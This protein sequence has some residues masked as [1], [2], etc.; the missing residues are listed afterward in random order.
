MG[1]AIA[2]Q[3][4]DGMPSHLEATTKGVLC[5]T[6]TSDT[7]SVT[8]SKCL[9]PGLDTNA[10]DI[11]VAA[12]FLLLRGLT[13]TAP[14]PMDTTTVVVSSLAPT[15]ATDPVHV[16]TGD[17]VA[18]QL[19]DEMP[20]HTDVDCE[21]WPW[22]SARLTLVFAPTGN[23]SGPCSTTVHRGARGRLLHHRHCRC[24]R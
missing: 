19:L 5:V 2:C 1:D 3:L 7:V 13:M 21:A 12:V 10:G 11:H 6:V 8:S 24:S 16:G 20:P 4:F 14:S 18:H 22:L 17:L 15:V 9:T 23:L